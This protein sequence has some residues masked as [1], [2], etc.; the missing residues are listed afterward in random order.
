MPRFAVQRAA[1]G[2]VKHGNSTSNVNRSNS[3]R[4][5]CT[6]GTRSTWP[7]E[8]WQK[9]Q[10]GNGRRTEAW[11]ETLWFWTTSYRSYCK[12][13]NFC[14]YFSQKAN[15]MFWTRDGD[16]SRFIND[17]RH[18]WYQS[19]S[20]KAKI[21]QDTYWAVVAFLWILYGIA[22]SHC[23]PLF[24][25][26]PNSST[27]HYVRT[28]SERHDLRY[29]SL[30][31]KNNIIN[32]HI[33][34]QATVLAMRPSLHPFTALFF[35]RVSPWRIVDERG[36]HTRNREG[37]CR[38]Q[39]NTCLGMWAASHS[40][41]PTTQHYGGL[42]LF[43]LKSPGKKSWVCIQYTEV[44]MLWVSILPVSHFMDAFSII[45][46]YQATARTRIKLNTR[47]RHCYLEYSTS[48]RKIW[49]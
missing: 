29:L 35:Q 5:P 26:A 27:C 3:W 45:F 18:K 1:P 12:A 7:I 47:T 8:T 23:Y 28:C 39:R 9:K 40:T 17:F 32:K 24:S 19:S 25:N 33:T 48:L 10:A 38:P 49:C 22:N 37:P 16:D 43:L 30:S 4:F 20:W 14:T 46:L 11:M 15:D 6:H 31:I 36:H 42:A 21:D 2:A 13:N 34:M 41:A 44:G